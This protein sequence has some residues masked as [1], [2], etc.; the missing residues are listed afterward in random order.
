MV[1]AVSSQLDEETAHREA[2]EWLG[3]SRGDA[4]SA[5]TTLF[6]ST[7]SGLD[8]STAHVWQLWVP[9]LEVLWRKLRR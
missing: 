5:P 9:V 2:K 4:V 3:Q 7:L 8:A 6:C 1:T